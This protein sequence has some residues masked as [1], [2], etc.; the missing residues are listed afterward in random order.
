MD[1]NT[2]HSA[3]ARE[4]R[5][6]LIICV[7]LDVLGN[8]SYFVPILGEFSDIPFASVSGL[9][10]AILFWRY[11]KAVGIGAGLFN[12]VEETLPFSDVIPS[13]TFM[14][15]MV[16]VKGETESFKIF[17]EQTEAKISVSYRSGAG[18]DKM[19]I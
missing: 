9:I 1:Y 16:F 10:M 3:F 5:N 12:M 15:F 4:K 8:I 7:L 6:K 17:W 11:G 18:V 14:W 13:A 19:M 2:V